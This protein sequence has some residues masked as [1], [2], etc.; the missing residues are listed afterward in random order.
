MKELAQHAHAMLGIRLTKDQ[1]E[2]LTIYERELL[3]WN[4][5]FNLTAIDDPQKVRVKHFLDS[6]TCLCVLRE[7]PFESLI[8]VGTGAGFPG[9]P[10]KIIYPQ[11]RLTLVESV[12]KKA[13]FCRH[14]VVALGLENV[15]VIQERA[16][17]VG[18]MPE[19]RE[20]YDWAVARA[21]AILP[22][23]AEYLLPLVRIGGG[24][25]AMKGEQA[26]AEA[27]AAEHAARVLG[28]HLRR[29]VPIHLPGVAEERY[30]VVLD[31]VAATP[32]AYPRRVGLPA[33]KPL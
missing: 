1:V 7:A 2:A 21:V 9:L 27:H 10:L 28:G 33:K 3:D 32:Q 12:G 18:Q 29:L 22:V 19:H 16:E 24:M 5:R 8:D 6:L 31:K 25:L 30:L 15:N 23:L 11:L 17:A 14:M 20:Q 26:P 4:T 13:N